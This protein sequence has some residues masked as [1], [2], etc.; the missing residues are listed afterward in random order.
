MTSTS[1]SSL[2]QRNS[3]GLPTSPFIRLFFYGSLRKGCLNHHLL[4]DY[5]GEEIVFER[6]VT[7][8]IPGYLLSLMN[9]DYPYMTFTSPSNHLSTL[10][11]GAHIIGETYLVPSCH[12]GLLKLDELE[13][14]YSALEVDVRTV[15][16]TYTT[17]R[18]QAYVIDSKS[19]LTVDNLWLKVLSKEVFL[20]ENGDWYSIGNKEKKIT[21]EAEEKILR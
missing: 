4:Y 9:R 6:L 1:P 12:P 21:N 15:D 16:E 19:M 14:E 3:I 2:S 11:K 20:V 5:F 10:I 7:T 13:D 8:T 17:L 18:A